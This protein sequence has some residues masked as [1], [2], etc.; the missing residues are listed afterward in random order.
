[1]QQTGCWSGVHTYQR[2]CLHNDPQ[3]WASGLTRDTCCQAQGGNQSVPWW[4][5]NPT[6]RTSAH[7]VMW[8]LAS[9]T[10]CFPSMH[11]SREICCGM[12]LGPRCWDAVFTEARCCGAAPALPAREVQGDPTCWSGSFNYE[13]CCI[14]AGQAACWDAGG[15][16]S[17]AKCCGDVPAAS[18]KPLRNISALYVLQRQGR[19]IKQADVSTCERRWL[20]ELDVTD[21]LA[22]RRMQLVAVTVHRRWRNL[23]ILPRI[24]RTAPGFLV[25]IALHAATYLFDDWAGHGTAPKG[26]WADV[27]GLLW[28]YREQISNVP[29][30]QV[31][32]FRIG[33]LEESIRQRVHFH[34]DTSRQEVL[35]E[36]ITA[37][38]GEPVGFAARTSDSFLMAFR[39]LMEVLAQL[40]IDYVPIQGTLISL[41]RYGDFPA[42]RLSQGKEDVVDNDAE[43]MIILDHESDLEVVGRHIS[44]GL[45]ALGWPPCTNPH[46]RKFVCFSLRHAIPCK[47]EIYAVAK[48]PVQQLIYATRSCSAGGDCVYPP[49]FPFHA[50]DFHL[51]AS[52]IYPMGWCRVGSASW[53]V[54]CPRMPMELLRGWNVGEYEKQS[55]VPSGDTAVVPAKS[56]DTASATK[57]D[58]AVPQAPGGSCIALPVVSKDRDMGDKR[59]QQLLRDGLTPEDLRLL[60][61]YARS[62]HRQGFA[63]FYRH[64][65]DKPCLW[66]QRRILRGDPHIGLSRV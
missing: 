24:A 12:P 38:N 25:S 45:E 50:W 23:K 11:L 49:A 16:Y 5:A 21:S 33:T 18:R 31:E 56:A 6:A 66:R 60:H 52:V 42:G 43:V 46:P 65:R 53:S 3:C 64:L 36:R 61:S 19:C 20:S 10:S 44:L 13:T 62:L 55:A 63:S 28:L 26:L 30:A 54:P 9:R 57:N 15:Q 39:E 47:L 40:G 35:V 27:Q 59:N 48:D 4:W 17:F 14:G 22:D 34:Y 1:M 7:F 29:D 37:A 2:C 32:P 58:L 51:P 41:V 8:Y